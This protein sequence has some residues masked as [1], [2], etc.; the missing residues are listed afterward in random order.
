MSHI[1]LICSLPCIDV[2]LSKKTKQKK[3]N[4][5]SK[6]SKSVLQ[7]PCPTFQYDKQCQSSQNPLLLS[8]ED[9]DLARVFQRLP[10]VA[11]PDSDHLSVI[12]Q[13]S[14]NFC[15]LLARWQC[16]LLKVRVE[17]FYGLWRETG[18]SFAL[19]GWFTTHK[20]HQI[21]LALL[22]P[23]FCFRQPL[24][25]HWLKLLSTFRGY[26]QLFKPALQNKPYNKDGIYLK[27]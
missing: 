12:V 3:T 9:I 19:F 6:P 13:L 23:V 14:C 26:V 27:S 18:A 15:N 1:V 21:L 4:T 11:E 7:L 8:L 5:F 22:V 10:S 24:L 25:Q 16:I 17:D 2:Y 20:L